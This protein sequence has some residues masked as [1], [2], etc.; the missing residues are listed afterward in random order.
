MSVARQ[1]SALHSLY[2]FPFALSLSKRSCAWSRV[3]SIPNGKISERFD[4]LNAN[5]NKRRRGR[6]LIA[7]HIDA[8]ARHPS[9]QQRCNLLPPSH[10]PMPRSLELGIVGRVEEVGFAWEEV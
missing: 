4:K 5:G 3:A 1:S 2:S 8:L 9:Q 10:S 7:S 6:H